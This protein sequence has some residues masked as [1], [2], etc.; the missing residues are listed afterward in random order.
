V[1]EKIQPIHVESACSRE[2]MLASPTARNN[3][4]PVL[5]ALS[6]RAF[7]SK[8]LFQHAITWYSPQAIS[9]RKTILV[10]G[11]VMAGLLALLKFFE[12]RYFVK[13]F[14]LEFY[15]GIVAVL[16]TG[17]GIWAG[18]RLTRPK[19]VRVNPDFR[20]N[21]AELDRRGISRREYEVLELIAQGLS[22]QEIAER[23][24]VSPNTVK[25]HSSNLFMKLDV[26]RRTEAVKRA[27]ELQLLP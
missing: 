6:R 4:I 3:L 5:L 1:A 11:L 17:L 12:Y 16:F 25:T 10:Y 21:Q 22:N 20:L 15:L 7:A 23:L 27:Q 24:F 26:R 9:M 19:V 18:L 8:A 14:T 2:F 13:D